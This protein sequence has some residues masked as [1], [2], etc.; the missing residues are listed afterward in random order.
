LGWSGGAVEGLSNCG[1]SARRA[2][3]APS[4]STSCLDR[5]LLCCYLI[6]TCGVHVG[7]TLIQLSRRIKTEVKTTEGP[8]V[9]GFIS[10]GMS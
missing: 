5:P 9:S 3:A 2:V 6:L 8:K 10:W 4:S 7:L 1:S